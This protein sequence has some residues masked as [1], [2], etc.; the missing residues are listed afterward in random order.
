MDTLEGNKLTFPDS[1]ELRDHRVIPGA[2][3][4]VYPKEGEV[5]IS[6]VGGGTGLYGDGISTFE[7]WDFSEEAPEGYLTIIEINE[8][9][10]DRSVNK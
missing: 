9:L 4:W 6:V 10:G 3:Q 2:K 8:R 1:F 7:Y 5:Q